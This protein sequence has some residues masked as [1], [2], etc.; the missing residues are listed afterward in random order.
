[1]EKVFAFSRRETPRTRLLDVRSQGM[2]HEV[3]YD[4]THFR[5]LSSGRK[6]RLLK[7]LNTTNWRRERR[8]HWK[9][10]FRFNTLLGRG[11]LATVKT[12]VSILHL[13]M[14]AYRKIYAQLLYLVGVEVQYIWE[15]LLDPG[16]V[17]AEEE[18]GYL[19]CACFN[20]DT[21]TVF[22]PEDS[23]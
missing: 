22:E 8:I 5:L 14:D 4:I 21:E 20:T 9:Q 7:V 16:T 15:D 13:I 1:M 23:F 2:V 12:I 17:N 18:D 6:W 11:M 19:V 10:L 3:L